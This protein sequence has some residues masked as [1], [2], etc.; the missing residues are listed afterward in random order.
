MRHIPPL[1]VPRPVEVAAEPARIA[2]P[3]VAAIIVTWNRH[4]AVDVVLQALVAAG[5]EPRAA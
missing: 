1:S 3:R 4:Q 5:T 2:E